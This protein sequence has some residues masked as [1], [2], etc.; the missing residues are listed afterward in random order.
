MP[1]P[2]PSAARSALRGV[3]GHIRSLDVDDDVGRARE[4]GSEQG[5]QPSDSDTATESV[6]ARPSN[7][8]IVSNDT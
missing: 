1:P 3:A 5:V 4:V 2:S 8:G 6:S 7:G